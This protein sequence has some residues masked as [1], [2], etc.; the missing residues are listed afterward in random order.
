MSIVIRTCQLISIGTAT[1]GAAISPLLLIIFINDLLGLFQPDTLESAFAD[2]LAMACSDR[3][4][5]AAQ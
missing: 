5:A 2:D 4:K 1:A 3:H